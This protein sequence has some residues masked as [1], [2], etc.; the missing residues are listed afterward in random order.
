MVYC[1]KFRDFYYAMPMAKRFEFAQVLNASKGYL[2][3]IASGN[4]QP[5]P[6]FAIKLDRES[7][8]AVT[9]EELRPDVDWAHIRGTS[10]RKAAKPGAANKRRETLESK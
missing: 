9:V 3:L 6:E 10:K 1:M 7:G 2:D 4:R 8:G 5:S